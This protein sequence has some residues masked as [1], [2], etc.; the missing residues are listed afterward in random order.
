[1]G[2]VLA[3]AE[4]DLEMQRTI[5]AEQALCRDRPFLGYRDARQ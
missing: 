5:F 1:M 2:E 4:T 3:S